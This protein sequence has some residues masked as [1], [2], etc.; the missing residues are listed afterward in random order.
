MQNKSSDE[1]VRGYIT[2]GAAIILVILYFFQK[3]KVWFPLIFSTYLIGIT[4]LVLAVLMQISGKLDVKTWLSKN[5]IYFYVLGFIYF[6]VIVFFL[7]FFTFCGRWG[8]VLVE[9]HGLVFDLF[10]FGILLAFYNRIRKEKEQ[11]TKEIRE[12]K[13]RIKG[14]KDELNDYRGWTE[15]EAAYRIR[16]LINRLAQE[17]QD[18][19]NYND[20]HLGK[21]HKLRLRGILPKHNKPQLK[22]NRYKFKIA[23][24]EG[25]NLQKEK[26]YNIDLSGV[27][28]SNSELDVIKLHDAILRRTIFHGA[29]LFNAEF[30][31]AD[32]VYAEF[33]KA[34]LASAKFC[35]ANLENADFS[36]ATLSFTDFSE[37]TLFNTD[38]K[39]ADFSSVILKNAKVN[40]I[41]WFQIQKNQGVLKVEEVEKKYFIAPISES[42]KEKRITYFLIKENDGIC[43]K[44]NK[45]GKKCDKSS[46][47]GYNYCSKHLK[48]MK[49]DKG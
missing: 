11:Q 16:G 25:V 28:L 24:L 37:A 19:I 15:S 42:E 43:I 45:K 29:G 4:C 27:N 23:S 35:G 44:L 6:A 39:G 2:G 8:D 22:H 26:L 34:Y 48:K 30:H 33:N 46:K 12:K 41:D 14:Y 5:P 13:Y 38:F 20:L 47:Q 1:I 3:E 10:V 9:A 21:L 32:L 31:R 7:D 40:S 17:G 36:G 49:T 18:N